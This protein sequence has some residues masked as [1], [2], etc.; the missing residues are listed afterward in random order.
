M[1]VAT[2]IAHGPST[3]MLKFTVD[4][5]GTPNVGLVRIEQP[6]PYYSWLLTVHKDVNGPVNVDRLVTLTV[7]EKSALADSIE[8]EEWSQRG[9]VA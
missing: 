1:Q 9:L 5:G 6:V 8:D 7:N 2:L 4:T 3:D